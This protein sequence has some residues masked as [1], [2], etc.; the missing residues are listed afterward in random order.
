MTS[1]DAPATRRRTPWRVV[2]LGIV[3]VLELV[4]VGVLVARPDAA[5]GRT[6]DAMYA[7][8]ADLAAA[9]PGTPIRVWKLPA[10]GIDGT[11]YGVLYHSRSVGGADIAVS[12]YVAIPSGAAPSGGR[13]IIS[14]GHGTVGMADICAPSRAPAADAGTINPLLA[15]GW[16]VTSTDFEGIGGPGRHPYLVGTSEAR[17]MIDVVRAARALLGSQASRTYVAWGISQGGHAALFARQIAAT[18]A[19]DLQLAGVVAVAPVSDVA[20]FIS[21]PTIVPQ[22]V[23]LEAVAGYTTAYPALRASDVLDAVGLAH[24]SGVDRE[25]AADL[26][27]EVASVSAEGLR[28]ADPADLADWAKAFQANTP[29][30]APSTVPVLLVQGNRDPIVPIT[31][32]LKLFERLCDAGAAASIDVVAGGSHADVVDSGRAAYLD[33]M[34]DRIAG[35][36]A[37]S[38]CTT[39]R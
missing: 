26:N 11:V 37:P 22:A 8:P 24:L 30:F 2:V 7:P 39:G 4:A 38:T 27:Q 14:V 21:H 25:C 23:T 9:S 32:S 36:A 28:K 10:G 15:K 31:S 34:A 19:P 35:A 3:V 1:A 18:W 33:W 29:G 13:P 5:T 20:G 16:I 17:S 6:L 12:G